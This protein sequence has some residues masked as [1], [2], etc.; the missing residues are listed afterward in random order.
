MKSGMKKGALKIGAGGALACLEI[1]AVVAGFILL[2]AGFLIWRL[3][4]GPVDVGFARPYIEQAL[5]DPVSGHSV[6]LGRV[7][8]E[9]PDLNGP[10]LLELDQVTLNKQGRAVLSVENVNLGL[11]MRHLMIGRVEPVNIILTGPSLQLVR[12]ETNAIRL[13]LEDAIPEEET[14]AGES[15][16][17][18]NII[19]DL[20]LPEGAMDR[21][22][23][24]DN[25]QSLEIRRARMVVEDYQMGVTWYLSPLDMTFARDGK[26]LMVT[27]SVSVPGRMGQ[28]SRIQADLIYSRDSQDFLAS[29]HVQDF[30]PR[31]FSRKV[32]G[33]EWLNDH[34]AL[35]NGTIALGFDSN[36]TINTAS[37]SLSSEN[38]SIALPDVYE[39]PLPFEALLL[40]V[41][42]DKQNNLVDIRD[43]TIR[44]QG[45][46][47]SVSAPIKLQDAGLTAPVTISIPEMPQ[48]Q[49]AAFWPMSL[50]G[51]GAEI[52]LAQ[53]LSK[54]H[55]SGL[56]ARFDLSVL[57]NGDSRSI[58]IENIVSDFTFAA[59]DIDYRPPLSPITAASGKGHFENDTLTIDIA[60]ASLAS[61]AVPSAR[62][63]V[64][65]VIEGGG[66]AA[67]EVNLDGPLQTVFRYIAPEP[68]GVTEEKLGLKIDGVKGQAKL[69]V[70]VSFPTIRNLLAEQV[71]VK[72]EGSLSDVLLPD[73]VKTL[74]LSGGPFAL[75]IAE[76][77]AELGG[78]G[79]LD[80]R[81]VRFSWKEFVNPDGKPFISRITADLVADPPLRSAMGIGLEDWI[82]GTFPVDVT[83][84]EYPDRAEA[85]VKTDLS[86]GTLTI[87]PFEYIKPPGT[88]G[89]A[90]CT[91]LFKNGFVQEVRGLAVETPELHLKDARFT[92]DRSGGETAL[93]E[94]TIPSFVLGENNLKLDLETGQSGLLKI[95][96][97]GSFLDASPFLDDK[98]KTEPRDGPPLMISANVARMRTYPDRTVDT[99]KMY[100]D[101]SR[102]G[103]INQFEMDAVAGQGAIYL[104]LKPDSQGI[105][106]V[107]LEADDAGAALRAFNMYENVRGGKLAL[108]GA[109]ANAR[110][111]KILRGTAE[112]TDFNVVNAPVLAQLLNIISLTG[113]QQLLGGEGI[114]FSRLESDFTWHI[115]QQGDKYMVQN[116]RTSGSS[117]GL[118]FDGAIDKS[119]GQIAMEGTIV[120]VSLI[121]EIVKGIPL[122]GDILT[123][124]GGGIIA[125]TYRIDGPIK[126]P[127][128]SVN[129]L[130]VLAPGILRKMLFEG[131]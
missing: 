11:S 10:L 71:V 19:K 22:S 62:A 47:L 120:P 15:N 1:T 2:V 92:F 56:Q 96:V 61:M 31:V 9:W 35:I 75:K 5:H 12:T 119:T 76:G 123:G 44:T 89:S 68:I 118:T 57:K 77:A 112:L 113:I 114:Y 65:R 7:V 41:V 94:G 82:D 81:A 111:S 27:A 88:A 101:M 43:M 116:G 67:I 29:V 79:K 48:S 28:D 40:E 6:S 84:T 99:V 30:D 73:V 20:S 36:F 51:D 98:R 54:G 110:D 86:T 18:M 53:K 109:A 85:D 78:A 72:A 128:V 74:D 4:T 100:L 13:T 59:M 45:V 50:R 91:V 63:T 103:D 24:I 80:G 69:A 107:R 117:V 37:V 34:D 106:A 122:I 66:T 39:K 130:S 108:N 46:A 33:L 25:L 16:P 131:E 70:H 127:D 129:P 60:G 83:Y 49:I 104:R 23:P 3:T 121:N 126:K 52:W 32:E 93:R 8:V 95:N 26:G 125:A 14:E 38:G 124:G 105:M 42:Y 17:L 90:N 55:F 97:S 21:R 115:R 87:A 102:A 64:S 58:D